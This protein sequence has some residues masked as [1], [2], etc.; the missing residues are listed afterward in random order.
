MRAVTNIEDTTGTTHS[1]KKQATRQAA[2]LL[3]QGMPFHS[4]YGNHKLTTKFPFKAQQSTIAA[5]EKNYQLYFLLV[6]LW[7]T[8]M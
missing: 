4:N 2:L 8:E 6:G 7:M 3:Y 1:W 5:L